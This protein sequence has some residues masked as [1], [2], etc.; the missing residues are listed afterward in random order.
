MKKFLSKRVLPI[1]MTV[2]MLLSVCLPIGA[3]SISAPSENADDVY[4]NI[5]FEDG[6]LR[7]QLNPQKVYEMVRDGNVTKDEL[8]KFMPEDVWAVLQKGQGIALDDLTELLSAYVTPELIDEI[9]KIVPMEVLASRFDLSMFEDVLTVDEL[10]SVISVDELMAGVSDEAISGL[11]TAEVLELLLNETVK[12]EVLT[13]EFVEELLFAEGDNSVIEAILGGDLKPQL[14]GLVDDAVVSAVLSE[15]TNALVKLVESKKDSL[16]ADSQVLTGFSNYLK[17]HKDVLPDFL[18]QERVK[19]GLKQHPEIFLHEDI[20]EILLADNV[21]NEGNLL[22]LFDGSNAVMAELESLFDATAIEKVMGVPSFV[23]RLTANSTL[24]SQLVTPT[25]IDSLYATGC[26]SPEAVAVINETK[27]DALKNDAAAMQAFCDE[28]GIELADLQKYHLGQITSDALL[29]NVSAAKLIEDGYASI[30][31]TE[32]RAQ[33][34]AIL[35]NA[36]HPKRGEVLAAVTDSVKADGFDLDTYWGFVDE[37][38]F[39]VIVH[40]I[41]TPARIHSWFEAHPEVFGTLFRSLNSTT[42]DGIY[43]AF[44]DMPEED[45]LAIMTAHMSDVASTVGV[46][47][48]FEFEKFDPVALIREIGGEK[49]YFYFVDKK[50]VTVEEIAAA[51]GN[52]N[53]SEGYKKLLRLIGTETILEKIGAAPFIPYV[54]FTDIVTAAGGYDKAL[55]WYTYEEIAAIFREIGVDKLRAFL[56]DTG[57][58]TDLDLKGIATEIV[59]L[60]RD[61]KDQLKA[62]AKECVNRLSQIFLLDVDSITVNGTRV[63]HYGTIDLQALV[64]ELLQAIPDID[65]F[66]AMSEGD[67]FAALGFEVIGVDGSFRTG[68]RV[69]VEF[70][71]DFTELQE[72]AEAYADYFRFDVS[73]D[74]DIAVETVL[75]SV[76]AD[77][78]EKALTSDRVPDSLKKKLLEL[79]S[80]TVT[81][82]AEMLRALTDEELQTAVDTFGEKAESIRDKAYDAIDDKFG[83]IFDKF[84]AAK[85]AEEAA[86]AAVEKIL[87]AVTDIQK[88]RRALDK[89]ADVIEA[90]AGTFGADTTVADWYV[91]NGQFV[92]DTFELEVN[93]Y[94]KIN[95]FIS[96]PDDIL[97][98]FNNNMT[99]S[100]S[101]SLDVTLTDVYRLQITDEEANLHTFFLPAGVSADVLSDFNLKYEFEAGWTMP[102]ADTELFADNLFLIEFYSENHEL[103]GTVG[104]T[105][106]K[107]PD[108]TRYPAVPQKNG[109]T[110]VWED[111]TDR[112]WTEKVIKVYPVYTAEIY[113]VEFYAEGKLVD[114]FTYT[115]DDHS[116]RF[117][118]DVPDHS[119]PGYINGAWYVNGVAWADYELTY[120]NVTVTAVYELKPFTGSIVAYSGMDAETAQRWSNLTFEYDVEHTRLSLALP[121]DPTNIIW[122]YTFDTFY[123]DE[124]HNGVLDKNIDTRLE[125]YVPE[126]QTFRMF[127]MMRSTAITVEYSLPE[128]YLMDPENVR[129]LDL[130]MAFDLNEY[131]VTFLD[132]NG[133]P[134]TEQNG[135]YIYTILDTSITTP[136]VPEIAGKT[137]AWYVCDEDG[138]VTDT[139]W[140]AYDMSASAR[141]IVVQ[142]VYTPIDYT[143][144]FF[145]KN[146]NE[147]GKFTYNVED[148]SKVYTPDMPATPS[149]YVDGSGKWYICDEYDNPTDVEWNPNN[150]FIG[151]FIVKAGY[152]P[153]EYTVTFKDEAGNPLGSDTYTVE[154]YSL[155]VPSFADRTAEGYAGGWYVWDETTQKWNAWS[156]QS[157]TNGNV[158]VVLRYVP[159][160]Y[161]VSFWAN[162]VLYAEQF[163]TVDDYSGLQFVPS[164]PASV[165]A[166]YGNGKWYVFVEGQKTVLW[167]DYEYRASIG[168]IEVRAVYEVIP[169]TVTFVDAK[170][171]REIDSITYT[172]NN[173]EEMT[174]PG[175]PSV[176]YYENGR[177]C[178]KDGDEY[179]LWDQSLN[180]ENLTVYAV[181]DAIP[182]AVTFVDAKT[183]N[184]LN[185]LI[186]TFDNRNSVS[187]PS[188]PTK[189]HYENGRWCLKNGDDYVLWNQ[190]LNCENLT[191]YAVYDAT[192]YTV[193]FKDAKTGNTL[194]ILTITYTVEDDLTAITV[195]DPP[196]MAYYENGRWC[197]DANGT[198]E[199]NESLNYE[200]LT[201]Y[202]VYDATL[203]TVTFKDAK[204]GA[205]LDT[206]SY[207]VENRASATIPSVPTKTHYENGRWCLEANGTTEW[208]ESLNCEN[209]TVYAVYDAT[210][211]TVTFKDAKT[212][213][214]LDTLSYTVE[215]RDSTTVPAVAS[216]LHYDTDGKWYKDASG[217]T[218][219]NQ[220]LNYEN[221]TVYAIYSPHN[222]TASYTYGDVSGSVSFN[223]EQG[224]FELPI[225]TKEHY[226]FDTWYIDSDGVAG[227]S[228]GDIRL[229]MQQAAA[230]GLARNS[231]AQSAMFLLPTGTQMPGGDVNLYPTFTAISYDIFFVEGDQVSVIFSYTIENWQT[232]V[233]PTLTSRVG[234]TAQWC[235]QSGD[236]YLPWSVDM[237]QNGGDV[238]VYAIYTP[239]TYT[240]TFKADGQVVGTVQFTVEQT[241]LLG[242]PAVPAKKGYNGVWSAYEIKAED[243]TIEAVYTLIQYT[244]T[245]I[246]DGIEIAKVNFTVLD[247]SIEEPE[248]PA[249]E[250]YTGVWQSYELDAADVVIHA[251]YTPIDGGDDGEKG[252]F[253]WWILILIIVML[254]AALIIVILVLKNRSDDD[255]D[256]TPPAPVVAPEPEPEPEPEE[257]VVLETV[258]VETADSLMSDADAIAAIEIVFASR[259]EGPKGI[260]N[261]D[262][263]NEAFAAGETVDLDS[264][265]AKK[266][267]AKKTTRYKVLANGHLDKPLTVVADQ[268]SVQAIKMITLTGGHAVQK[269]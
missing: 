157:L 114:F 152:T 4:Y 265:K 101:L 234:Y 184:T 205:T 24:M 239:I 59:D 107:A 228:A 62:L 129:E 172:V 79:P 146:G 44:H 132:N 214:T 259:V 151:D 42:V 12:K 93:L 18:L 16:L 242:I 105:E 181:Y 215:N 19:N 22:T 110:G 9:K 229:T 36:N 213:T 189:T 180:L 144:T 99:V 231:A 104:Y 209:L 136:E 247:T 179:E 227:P 74:M 148:Y 255:D 183:G 43:N 46:E 138:N 225:P 262:A 40:D 175:V 73:D 90:T 15:S 167:A 244:A 120:G 194:D 141:D 65:D 128:G 57:I 206:L 50:H 49:G 236:A 250:G 21:I 196:Q 226:V 178:L 153:I 156:V 38:T 123:I 117:T 25:L 149:Y 122:G 140:S 11:I 64:T 223:V 168:N 154:D 143:V 48:F 173:R 84:G 56:T 166:G 94:E 147:V 20:I 170:T 130:V 133:N 164:V 7:I 111:F 54:S 135:D 269:K 158:T 208:N 203:Y 185:T 125:K 266:L 237:L 256:T 52:G 92:T 241:E 221:L 232:I 211:Y 66:L 243:M 10:T 23:N 14:V 91:A 137:G 3:Y 33:L 193:T 109:Y 240:A 71:G 106:D 150:L 6:Q 145:D 218:E 174:I 139:L 187:V 32:A 210:Q 163:Y 161:T 197:L 17:A 192:K 261:I 95:K 176:E 245:F 72:F 2:V 77:L 86:K 55:R 200:N 201:V 89:A 155:T 162:D 96:L 253:P 235:Y 13:E 233:P 115:V 112:L 47:A 207:T 102:A 160:Q 30:N 68:L 204:T 31:E 251:V 258:D 263:I 87:G 58:V 83:S 35:T 248:V 28:Y 212:G 171:G 116:N 103:V 85:K 230:F 75:P 202:A 127:R 186:Y 267:L 190:S 188:V 260:V 61:K 67:T 142:A 5:V 165:Q 257:P 82:A 216:K 34:I 198:T 37:A 60:L 182:Y 70:I 222:Y 26:I 41:L 119:N 252:G 108:E 81:D 124:D 268:F 97:P 254:L 76:A 78:Y 113:K 100:G 224:G 118:P 63:A 249:K 199:W 1:F 159:I 246:A 39:D 53:A 29:A 219:W 264:L 220:E 195:S 98:I 88:L 27:I 169:F 134:V 126:A 177:W 121:E 217:T 8:S 51:I 80:M 238:T 131:S 69:S 45:L 191:V